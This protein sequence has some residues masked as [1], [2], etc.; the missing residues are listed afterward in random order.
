MDSANGK[1]ILVVEDDPAY[2]RLVVRMLEGAGYT[3]IAAE[4]FA[5]A[6]TIIESNARIDL[7]LADVAMPAGTPHGMAIGRMAELR[8]H[9]LK[10]LYMSGTYD[11]GELARHSPSEKILKKPFTV[12]EL[13]DAVAEAFA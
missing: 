9:N 8:R 11:L 2:R 6:I 7:L 10:V 3:V 1:S 12:R 4:D 5:S 13:T